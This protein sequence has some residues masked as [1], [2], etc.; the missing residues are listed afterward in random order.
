VRR[1]VGEKATCYFSKALEPNC[2]KRRFY[3]Q[4][5]IFRASESGEISQTY[6]LCGIGKLSFVCYCLGSAAKARAAKNAQILMS[7]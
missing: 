7:T 4:E 5:A 6:P 2:P 3:S 1:P